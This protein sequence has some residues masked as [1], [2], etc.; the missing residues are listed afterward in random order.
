MECT[1]CQN[2]HLEHI[3]IEND[4]RKYILCLSCYL[5]FTHPQHLLPKSTA[6]AHYL[7]H[8]NT[9]EQ[10][11]YRKFLNRVITPAL[12]FI[13]PGMK[14]L[15]YGCGPTPVLSKILEEKGITCYN[16]DPLFDFDHPLEIYDFV[17]ATECF[18]HFTVPGTDIKDL[19]ALIKPGGFLGLMTHQWETVDNFKKWYYKNDPTH[20]SFY[21]QKTFEYI[22]NQYRLRYQFN[23]SN[24]VVILKN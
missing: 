17:F 8:N 20:V 22:S 19:L 4:T 3:D 13:S 14:G 15:D 12:R 16:Y 9:I 7:N 1:L 5:I 2:I 23:D 18:E 10:E 6:K 21:H 24:R 11:G